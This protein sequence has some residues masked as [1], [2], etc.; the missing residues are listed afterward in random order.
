[1]ERLMMRPRKLIIVTVLCVAVVAGVL[2]FVRAANAGTNIKVHAGA[3]IRPP[4]DELGRMFEKKTGTRVEYSYKGS[5]C[6]LADICFSKQGDLYI[7][8]EQFYV[9]QAKERGFIKK[10]ALV[11]QMSTVLIVQKGNP[12]NIRGLSDLTR[13]GMRVG[14]GDPNAVAVGRAA[15]EVLVKAK[16]LKPVDEN[17]A[18]R[19]LNVV[20]LG[21]G[22]KLKHLDAAIVWDATAHLFRDDVV[23]IEI[24]EEWRVEAPIPVG[25][26]TFSPDQDTAEQYLNFLTSEEAQK[27]FL[28]HGYGLPP[29]PQE[30]E[31]AEKQD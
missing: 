28:K 24:P 19:A 17:V 31:R 20:E 22:V 15:N 12:K 8:G 11:A 30:H 5:G 9:D 10:S 1:V 29:K 16:L 6:L 27:V 21:I 26:L 14:M 13:K 18:A 3:G 23:M 4:L 25:L 7:P 2:V